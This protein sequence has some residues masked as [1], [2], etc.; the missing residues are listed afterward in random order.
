MSNTNTQKI[1]NKLKSNKIKNSEKLIKF[2]NSKENTE[3][4]KITKTKSNKAKYF[5]HCGP[6]NSG[7]TFNAVNDLL[8]SKNG[9]YLSPLR[10]LASENYQYIKEKIGHCNLFTGQ[11]KIDEDSPFTCYTVEMCDTKRHFETIIIDE[12]FMVSDYSR[13]GAWTNAIFNSDAGNIHIILSEESLSLF[14]KFFKELDIEFEVKNYKRLVPLEY[15]GKFIYNLKKAPEKTVFIV[16]SINSIFKYKEMLNKEGIMPSIIYGAMPPE[17]KK[18]EIEKF[19]KGETKYC[20]STDAIGMGI[21]LPCDNVVFLETMKF[22]GRDFRELNTTEILQISGRAGRY[23]LCDK[24]RVYGLDKSLINSLK[25]PYKPSH[26]SWDID[27][28]ILKKIPCKK[29]LDKVKVYKMIFLMVNKKSIRIAKA[30]DFIETLENV[31]RL[32]N[33]PIDTAISLLKQPISREIIPLLKRII[34]TIIKNKTISYDYI[35]FP[36]EYIINS[37][38]E[39]RGCVDFLKK[40]D[41]LI[42]IYHSQVSNIIDENYIYELKDERIEIIE[43]INNYLSILTKNEYKLCRGYGCQVKISIQSRHSHCDEC[44]YGFK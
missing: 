3:K 8:N 40:I 43:A 4:F 21:N 37:S 41:F 30:D 6:T 16:F 19:I 11:E 5:F 14:E 25:N 9:A 7:K 23:K 22:D 27:F 1:L 26:M 18:K 29:L 20:I 10:L 2:I 33:I 39:M 12:S 38:V 44:F 35:Q 28:E 31:P 17:S 24:G 42:C 34:K 32:D 13:G 15:T 36:N